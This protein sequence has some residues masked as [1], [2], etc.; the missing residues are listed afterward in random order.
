MSGKIFAESANLYQDQARILFDYYREAAERI[1]SEEER[2]EKD[3]AVATEYRTQLNTEI[4]KVNLLKNIA[5]IVGG[6]LVVGFIALMIAGMG[7]TM[8]SVMSIVGAL[9]AGGFGVK[10]L[11]SQNN[12]IKELSAT[13][14]KIEEFQKLH[15]EIF[16]DYKVSKLGVG[17]VP[18][19]GQIAFEDKSF[20]IDYTGTKNNESFVLQTLRQSD[21]FTDKISELEAL[22]KEVP[23]V[24]NSNETEVVDTDQYSTSI[25]QVTYHDYF[26]AL[27]RN[28]RGAAYCMND[29]DVTS[30]SLPVI[31]PESDYAK[32]LNEYATSNPRESATV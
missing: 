12:F 18:V 21:L 6:V 29:L 26:G 3:I 11:L 2:I 30:V 5:F 17:Y 25:Q 23:M 10:Q 28:L 27:D 4:A 32:Y 19:A 9:S 22:L 8:F 1:V 13:E 14:I 15:L 24:E 20:L 16:R 31:L 7:S